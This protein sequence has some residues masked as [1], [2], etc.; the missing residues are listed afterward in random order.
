MQ[1]TKFGFYTSWAGA[2]ASFGFTAV[3]L[4]QVAGI[5]Q[6]P[7]DAIF[8]YAFSLCIAP[9][10]LLAVLALYYV[11]PAEKKFYAHAAL[12]F[13][14][15]Y[16]VFVIMMYVVQLA[17]VIPFHLTDEVFVVTPHSFF[18][19]ID[20]LGY[21]NMGI[22]ALFAAFVFGKQT[23]QRWLFLAHGFVTPLIAFIYFYP[24]F[25]NGLLLMGLPWS[26]T[27]PACMIALAQY[28][29]KAVL[30]N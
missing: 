3:Q 11:V 28:F 4:L 8:I 19:T 17:S 21:I 22:A 27:A 7:I 5:T 1:V 23:T 15:L 30:L 20:A 14:V 13:A 24:A 10:F 12:L 16:N 2:T 18:W 26:V 9:P 25:S 6:Y 29:R